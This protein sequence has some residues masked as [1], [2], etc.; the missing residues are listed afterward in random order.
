MRSGNGAMAEEAYRRVDVLRDA[1]MADNPAMTWLKSIGAVQR[2]IL[3]IEMARD[4]KA[5]ELETESAKLLRGLEDR[6]AWTVRYNLACAYAQLAKY[7]RVSERPAF[8]EKAVVELDNLLETPYFQD[9]NIRSHLDEDTDLDPLRDRRTSND[10]W[11]TQVDPNASA[12]EAGI[13]PPSAEN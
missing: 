7:G 9:P 1:M 3:L 2:S 10:F 8:A 13:R 12:G 5:A 11:D 4:G 6:A